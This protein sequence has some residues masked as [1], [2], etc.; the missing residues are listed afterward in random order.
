MALILGVVVGASF[1]VMLTAVFVAT[2]WRV[3]VSSGL[4]G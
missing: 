1:S 2:A 3:L 4:V